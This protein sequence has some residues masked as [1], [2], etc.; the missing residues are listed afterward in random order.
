MKT[1]MKIWVPL[2]ALLFTVCQC[3]K[4]PG[5]QDPVRIPDRNFLNTLITLG[6]DTYFNKEISY[7]EAEAIIYLDV[8]NKLINDLK[9]IEAM[10]N[11]QTL[12]CSNNFLSELDLSGN[13]YLHTVDCSE[14]ELKT[15]DCSHNP[16][17]SFLDCRR[18]GLTSLNVTAN[19]KLTFLWAGLNSLTSLDISNNSALGSAWD[20]TANEGFCS[21]ELDLSYMPSLQEVCVW[22]LPFPP[23]D[24]EICVSTLGSPNIFFTADCSE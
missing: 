17:L 12:Y 19:T 9:G 1:L 22:A 4:D 7:F 18:N 10:A 2:T 5:P 23:V 11:L 14:N 6:F 24:R 3:E 20:Y 15:L 16:E 8:N 21:D 13:E